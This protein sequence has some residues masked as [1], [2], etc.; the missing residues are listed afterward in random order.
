M[1]NIQPAWPQNLTIK[2]DWKA[3]WFLHFLTVF[4]FC[5]HWC[6]AACMCDGEILQE[7]QTVVNCHLGAENWI[8]WKSRQCLTIEL[9]ISPA[10]DFYNGCSRPAR[11]TQLESHHKSYSHWIKNAHLLA[12]E[13]VHR[14]G[15]SIWVTMWFY[16]SRIDALTKYVFRHKLFFFSWQSIRYLYRDRL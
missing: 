5:I 13:L 14:R 16:F 7:L 4:L 6:F 8:F 3:G 12:T 9:S 11:A 2:T 10:P 1:F 15:D